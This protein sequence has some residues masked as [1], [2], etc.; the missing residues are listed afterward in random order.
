MS[1]RG[2]SC[3][4][5]E[6]PLRAVWLFLFQWSSC[7]F[8]LRRY[9]SGECLFF[10]PAPSG[11]TLLTPGASQSNPISG[12]VIEIS[13]QIPPWQRIGRFIQSESSCESGEFQDLLGWPFEPGF[14]I[15]CSFMG[16]NINHLYIVL[17]SR[18]FFP[19]SHI[20]RMTFLDTAVVMASSNFAIIW[21]VAAN[22]SR[23]L[24]FEQKS[25]QTFFD[26]F[27]ERWVLFLH[28]SIDIDRPWP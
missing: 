4:L 1:I 14:N 19:D 23:H 21:S 22:G 26:C 9:D 25:E 5:H 8:P 13:E 24:N 12:F 20:G 27:W 28:P 3:N 2:K 7:R 6:A 16:Y 11:S 15:W 17:S 18:H 10:G